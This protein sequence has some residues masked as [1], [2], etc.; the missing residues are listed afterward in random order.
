MSEQEDHPEE[1][2]DTEGGWQK[3]DPPE[4]GREGD[5]QDSGFE[6]RGGQAG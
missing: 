3:G 2:K 4:E 1:T 6:E 5:H